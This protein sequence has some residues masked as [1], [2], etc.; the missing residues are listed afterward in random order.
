MDNLYFIPNNICGVKEFGHHGSLYTKPKAHAEEEKNA[1]GRT[2][3]VQIAKQH[4][5][6]QSRPRPTEIIKGKSGMPSKVG[7]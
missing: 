7:S 3:K 1:R 5:R 4:H 6:G 2:K